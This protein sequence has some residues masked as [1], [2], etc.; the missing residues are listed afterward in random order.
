MVVTLTALFGVVGYVFIHRKKFDL[1]DSL[2][3]DFTIIF[4]SH[5]LHTWI[6]FC[7][8]T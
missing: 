2:G 1:I 4:V 6:A 3:V 8:R 5:F 7:Q